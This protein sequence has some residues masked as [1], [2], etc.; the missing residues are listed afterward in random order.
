MNA[1]EREPYKM[2]TEEVEKEEEIRGISHS[3]WSF[4]QRD[5]YE[6]TSV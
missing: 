5:G 1:R 2:P 6:Y 3:R 4:A